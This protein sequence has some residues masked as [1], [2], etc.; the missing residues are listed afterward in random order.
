M[1]WS[2]LIKQAGNSLNLKNR[3]VHLAI[4]FFKHLAFM[5]FNSYIFSA[6]CL[7]VLAP[8]G[9]LRGQSRCHHLRPA[10]VQ[11]RKDRK[12]GFSPFSSYLSHSSSVSLDSNFVL[13]DFSSSTSLQQEISSN[14][15][16]EN[17]YIGCLFIFSTSKPSNHH[18]WFKLYS[19]YDLL[20]P[21]DNSKFKL[22]SNCK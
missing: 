7:A 5:L 15:W 18:F 19:L 20:I 8:H 16:L 10:L 13:L 3:G 11:H 17:L 12:T 14:W 6:E 21:I 2:V 22:E 1:D 4:A 9:F